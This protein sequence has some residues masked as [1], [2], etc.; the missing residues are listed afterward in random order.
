MG[1]RGLMFGIDDIVATFH[2][3]KPLL[4]FIGIQFTIMLLFAGSSRKLLVA[5]ALCIIALLL[6]AF[7][8]KGSVAMWSMIAIGLFNS[9]MW[10]N[11]FTLAIE[12]LKEYTSQGSSLLIIMI[13]GGAAIPML[14][15]WISDNHG[16]SVAYLLPIISYIYIAFFGAFGTRRQTV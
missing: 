7:I 13:S 5:F 8:A 3:I 4:I 9:I 16:L 11:I 15:G 14:V 2:V 1:E 10:S 6:T 12:D